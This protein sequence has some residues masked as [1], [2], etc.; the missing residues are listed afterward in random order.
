MNRAVERLLFALCLLH[1]LPVLFCTSVFAQLNFV[2]VGHT[3]NGGYF[4]DVA[5]SGPFA[6]VSTEPYGV[7]IYNV[8]N[9]ATP[10]LVGGIHNTAGSPEGL[11]ISSNFLF[12]A[13]Y[14]DGLRI[15]D[16]SSPTNPVLISHTN[17]GG[18]AWNTA[19]SGNY[20]YLANGNDGL[21]VY[22]VS[23]PTNV[24]NVG[25]TNNGG[26][27]FDVAISSNY[28]FLANAG[29]G[30]RI[31]DVS[32]PAN[33]VNVGH[34]NNGYANGILVSGNYAFALSYQGFGLSIYDVSDPT[35]PQRLSQIGEHASQPLFHGIAVSGSFLYTTLYDALYLLDIADPTTPIVA[36]YAPFVQTYGPSGVVL[37]NGF[38]YLANQ[39][40]GFRLFS[41]YGPPLGIAASGTN[42]SLFWPSNFFTFTVQQAPD[43][44]KSQWIDLTNRPVLANGTNQISLSPDG[45]VGFYRLR[46]Q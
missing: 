25:H 30:L 16:I 14:G 8:S 43:L 42:L 38:I 35:S 41:I 4:N 3:N 11:L 45:D 2:T 1:L 17:N 28:V 29:D 44:T 37:A 13:N 22:D 34:T 46:L 6:Y 39:T 27:A 12:L 10:L 21:R 40:D 15:Y 9:A 19:L 18:L 36:A 24:I 5:L 32:D 23:N 31:Y 33:P 20:L 7:R 26:Y